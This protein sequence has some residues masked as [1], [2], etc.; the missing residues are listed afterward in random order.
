[1][2]Q[3]RFLKTLKS[4]GEGVYCGLT[5][6]NKRSFETHIRKNSFHIGE[7]IWT[8]VQTKLAQNNTKK[9][10][11]TYQSQ[12]L[13]KGMICDPQGRLFSPTYTCKTLKS[14][15]K[16]YTHYYLNQKAIKEGAENVPVVRVPLKDIEEIITDQLRRHVHDY[17][18]RPLLESWDEKPYLEKRSA[19]TQLIEKIVVYPEKLRLVLKMPDGA[20]QE[21]DINMRFRRYGGRRLIVDQNGHDLKPF[22]T[23]KDQALIKALARAHKWDR[24]LK[25]GKMKSLDEIARSENIGR[26]YVRQIY[27]L[28]FLAPDIQR[29][30]LDGTQP[31]TLMLSR[32]MKGNIPI[33]WNEQKALFGF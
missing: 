16:K 12:A 9:D 25:N 17:D 28:I 4:L 15:E 10:Q 7:D 24:A 23:H 2:R 3:G 26:S 1:M 32:M 21:Q 22:K 13:L 19:L 11:P 29:A 8:R 5:H 6:Q 30:I 33:A 14:G 27:N 18:Q 20:L 31:R